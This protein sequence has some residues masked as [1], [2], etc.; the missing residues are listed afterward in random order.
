MSTI[1]LSSLHSKLV[2]LLD[3]QYLS[4]IQD[5]DGFLAMSLRSLS[6]ADRDLVIKNQ[7]EHHVLLARRIVTA[8]SELAALLEKV[9]TSEAGEDIL[10]AAAKVSWEWKKNVYTYSRIG[11]KIIGDDNCSLAYGQERYA[12]ILDLDADGALLKMVQDH[13]EDY[14]PTSREKREAELSEIWRSRRAIVPLTSDIP[15]GMLW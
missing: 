4:L 11:E 15:V 9:P 12:A 5:R 2:F 1:D 13:E 7:H 8:G 14:D 3:S 10:E 6:Q